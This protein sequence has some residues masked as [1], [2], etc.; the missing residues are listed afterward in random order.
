[1]FVKEQSQFKSNKFILHICKVQLVIRVKF[2]NQ[3][4]LMS[5]HFIH[6]DAFMRNVPKY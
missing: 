3:Q 4:R 6:F 5:T 1:M 2:P